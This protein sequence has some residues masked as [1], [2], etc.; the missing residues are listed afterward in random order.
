MTK[1]PISVS[2]VFIS[3]A[4]LVLTHFESKYEYQDTKKKKE[5]KVTKSLAHIIVYSKPSFD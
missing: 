2:S 1:K 4:L 5:I 3:L